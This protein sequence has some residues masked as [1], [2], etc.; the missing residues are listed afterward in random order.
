MQ[1][2]V[3]LAKVIVILVLAGC[4]IGCRHDRL[5]M[6]LSVDDVGPQIMTKNR[7]TFAPGGEMGN[8]EYKIRLE[9]YN[10]KLQAAQPQVFVDTGIPFIVRSDVTQPEPKGDAA[11]ANWSRV[12]LPTLVLPAFSV[13]EK[14]NYY[15]NFCS[16]KEV[17][18]LDNPDATEKFRWERKRDVVYS[19]LPP[20][21]SL[22]FL[23]DASFDD[24]TKGCRK[25]VHHS[26]SF[27]GSKIV[28]YGDRLEDGIWFNGWDAYGIA[29]VLKQMEDAGKIDVSRCKKVSTATM[30]AE[31]LS[32]SES[33]EVMDFHRA[34][35]DKYR[36]V[37]VLKSRDK[38]ISLRESRNIQ[39][40]L[41]QMIR[42]DFVE[43]YPS[44]SRTVIAIEFTEYVLEN[45]SIKGAASVLPL[46]V[47]SFD[48]DSNIRKGT[49]RIRIAAGQLAVAREYVK[50]NIE[51]IV[52]DK[53]IALV[54]G[55]IPPETSF[56]LLDESVR[57][58]ILEIR[59]KTE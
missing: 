31:G 9:S 26:M 56:Y 19:M 25:Y 51:T 13:G 12:L 58:E 29:V 54:V 33:I 16:W 44:A 17:E 50:R 42:N 40:T 45:G 8:H 55:E 27:I 38:D 21:P 1:K 5:A 47:L 7:Y 15:S 28:D 32:T 3:L 22:C 35:D 34:T 39:K 6:K 18:V 48:Y 23:G 24:E 36:Y 57:D 46:A 10:K 53:N 11:W 4:F 14:G 37:F 59:F 49:M 2:Q 20:L 52:R 43:S 30:P 41:R